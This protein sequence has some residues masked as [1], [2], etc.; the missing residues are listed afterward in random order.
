MTKISPIAAYLTANKAKIIN[1]GNFKRFVSPEGLYLG[2]MFKSEQNGA[3]AYSIEIIGEGLKKMFFQTTVI[4]QK[5]AYIANKKATLGVSLVPTHTY[6]FKS[7][8]DFFNNTTHLEQKTRILTNDLNLLAK[9]EETGVGLFD[10]NGP[11]LFRD[12]IKQEKTTPFK[13]NIV[14]YHFDKN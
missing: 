13:K 2:H 11:F 12:E 3:T 4:G 8:M 6:I 14:K 7:V 10:T 5:L 1:D 9:D